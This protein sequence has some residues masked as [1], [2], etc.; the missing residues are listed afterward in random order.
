MSLVPPKRALRPKRAAQ[1]NQPEDSFDGFTPPKKSIKKAKLNPISQPLVT[2]NS[3]NLLT[4]NEYTD[5]DSSSEMEFEDNSTVKKKSLRPRL[6]RS[7]TQKDSN[8]V[9]KMKPI[10]VHNISNQEVQALMKV[11][12]DK[13]SYAKKYEKFHIL[14]TNID[15]KMK[16]LESLKTKGHNF[17]S[18]TEPNQRQAMYVLRNHFRCSTEEMLNILRTE[19]I[20][21]SRVDFLIDNDNP[22]YLVKFVKGAVNFAVLNK[23][24]KII[25]Q[26]VVT[27]ERFIN[28]HKKPTQ[29]RNCQRWGHAASNCGHL[30]RCVKCLETH[31]RGECARK[32]RAVGEPHCVNCGK[33]GHPSN[34]PT[35]EVYIKHVKFLQSRKKA[36]QPRSFTS[37]QNAWARQSLAQEPQPGQQRS[38]AGGNLASEFF[39][40]LANIS[41]PSAHSSERVNNRN[42]RNVKET[43]NQVRECSRDKSVNQSATTFL[44]SVSNLQ[45]EAEQ[46]PFL[47]EA[48]EIAMRVMS[49]M[50]QAKSPEEAAAILLQFVLL[51]KCD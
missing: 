33:E 34:S 19:E 50:K 4:D 18:F 10:V 22:L 20:P 21:A 25:N 26:L 29:C 8:G 16:I 31:V 7:E 3:F 14:T 1:P 15:D 45:A 36:Q 51:K 44:E 5:V 30:N 47:A 49:R 27:W 6:G 13:V 41:G 43:Y 35:C 23:Q 9:G 17:H 38:G 39:P 46:I 24:H 42:I 40:P 2:N 11:C 48:V 32:D 28:K 12:K 37:P